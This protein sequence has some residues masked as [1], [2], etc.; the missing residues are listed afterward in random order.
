[1]GQQNLTLPAGAAK[2]GDTQYAVQLNS[3]PVLLQQLND[4]PIRSIDGTMVYLRDVAQVRDGQEPQINIVRVDGQRSVLLHILKNGNASTLDIVDGVKRL[5]PA[6]RAAAPEGMKIEARFDQSTF[7]SGAMKHVAI[8]GLIA[9]LLTA[10]FILLFLGSWRSTLIVAVS[11][12]L[13]ILASIALLTA[14]GHTLNLMTLGGLALAI[15]ILVDEATITIENIHRHRM[16]GTELREAIL[17]GSAE[18]AFP[19]L[20]SA[21]VLTIVF[22]PVGLLGGVARYLFIPLA[23]AVVFAILAS[24][25]LSRTL[26]PAMAQW[27][28]RHEPH[29]DEHAPPKNAFDRIHKGFNRGFESFRQRYAKALEWNLAHRATALAAMVLVV[30]GTSAVAPFVGREFFP[31]VVPG[32]FACT[33]APPPAHASSGPS[34]SSRRWRTK[35]ARCWAAMWHSFSTI[36][37]SQP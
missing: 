21:L 26:T 29:E 36:S 23:L 34:R 1:M 20:V 19:A 28:L 17:L 13:S 27:L 35:C 2:I 37:A 14:F 6:I 30:V 33:C 31:T 12:P 15:G 18:I 9:A 11:I 32:R 16:M 3:S 8:E 4:L 25:V 5:L 10:T 24:Y 7:V 22:V